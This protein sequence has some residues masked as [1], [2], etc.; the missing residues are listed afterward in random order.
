MTVSQPAACAKTVRTSRWKLGRRR[1]LGEGNSR[2]LTA[3]CNLQPA[4][5]LALGV[6]CLR[7]GW[8]ANSK[9][10]AVRP[11]ARVQLSAGAF[12]P[13]RPLWGAVHTRDSR[14][15]ATMLPL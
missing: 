12:R 14:A 8:S 5:D 3:V 10:S 7:R 13:Q 1:L 2:L 11:N 9:L 4:P 6:G 15:P